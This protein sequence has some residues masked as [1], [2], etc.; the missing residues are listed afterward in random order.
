[1][2]GLTNAGSAGGGVIY[3]GLATSR[4]FSQPAKVVIA[5]PTVG[6]LSVHIITPGEATNTFSLSEDG[7]T[8][9]A[10]SATPGTAIALG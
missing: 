4:T 5:Q 8:F 2:N 10:S 3:V 7:I 1:M 6:S 9:S